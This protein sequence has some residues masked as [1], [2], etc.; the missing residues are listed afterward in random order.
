MLS[1]IPTLSVLFPGITESAIVGIL[2]GGGILTIIAA[3]GVRLFEIVIAPTRSSP[4]S[5]RPTQQRERE[6]STWRMPPLSELPPA[7]LTAL[8]RV[9]LIVL[10][11]YLIVAAG[12]VLMRIVQ[13]A[14]VGA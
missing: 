11:G 6:C 12:L 10:R 4:G 7:R 13:R 9:W 14:M 5:V 3:I 1:M 2:V 8:N